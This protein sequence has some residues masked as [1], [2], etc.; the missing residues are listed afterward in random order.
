MSSFRNLMKQTTLGVALSMVLSIGAAIPPSHLVLA[1][2]GTVVVA[3]QTSCGPDT[4]EKLNTTLNQTAHALEAAV[5]TNGRLYEAGAYGAKGSPGAI[6]MRQRVA[7][8]IHDSNEYLIQAVDVAKTLTKATFEGGKLAILEKLSLA[9]TGLTVGQQTIDLV[10]QSVAGLINSAVAIVQLFKAGDVNHLNRII[11]V[12]NEH[13][14]A[15]A[16]V[17]EVNSGSEVFAE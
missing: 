5:D 6:A 10:L 1:T 11:P 17:R 8:V 7:R 14:T 13:L 3:T 12:L 9:A 4:L 2:V 15:F 16:H